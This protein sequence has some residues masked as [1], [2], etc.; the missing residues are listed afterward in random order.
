M[1][2]KDTFLRNLTIIFAFLFGQ[3]MILGTLFRQKRVGVYQSKTLVSGIRL[4]QRICLGMDTRIL[5]QL[6]IVL[7]S[8]GKRQSNDFSSLK[9]D[10]QLCFQCVPLFL[11]G[12]VSLLLF[13]G[14]S[15]GDSVA[16]TRI[17]S[18]LAS[19][20]SSAFRPGSEKVPSRISVFSTHLIP[21]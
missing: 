20:F 8:V 10:K 21:R 12:I 9:A 14:R 4:Q 3:R 18:Y 19:L 11:S 2:N 17:T 15:I 1:F 6:E 5:E 16:S 13:L 7:L